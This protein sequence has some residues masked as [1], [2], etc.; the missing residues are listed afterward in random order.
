MAGA[1]EKALCA[2]GDVAAL[3]EHNK[4]GPRGQKISKD[5]FGL[6]YQLDHLIATYRKPYIAYMDGITMGGG[7]GLSVHA[8]F[9][10]A[11]ERT[12]FAMPETTIG[13]FPDVGGGFFLPRL[14]GYTGRYLA[15]TS[16]RL[17][18]VNTF[19]AG[20][21]THYIH[22]SS[23]GDLTARLSE[24]DFD[25]QMPYGERL[26]L[27]NSTIEEFNS[28]LPQDEQPLLAGELRQAIDRCFR[29]PAIEE[30]LEA[31]KREEKNPATAEWAR[32]TT[33]TILDRSPTSVKVT[34]RQMVIGED[35]R[36]AEAFQN[37][38]NIASKFMEHP[39]FVE[40]VEA[41]LKK[42]KR[43][44]KWNPPRLEDVEDSDVDQFFR[45]TQGT[46]KLQLFSEGDYKNYDDF[47]ATGRRNFGLPTEKEILKLVYNGGA[48]SKSIVQQLAK[49]Y[50]EKTGLRE[51]IREV[52]ERKCAIDESG[53]LTVTKGY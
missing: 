14:D 32:N 29:Y 20:I 35:W 11:T 15:L 18:G 33:K 10:I 21:G 36:I 31:L 44:P 47:E 9:R 45:P 50:R 25:D 51:K 52:L 6:E 46:M 49:D 3:A 5:Y 34:L 26:E 4:T 28:G 16:E 30:I 41:L 7:V 2:G 23:L 53:H 39:D 42:P 19:Y 12:L 27:I 43:T 48:T 24:L 38:H 40:G 8:P 13:F 37:E 17:K 22:S 1:G